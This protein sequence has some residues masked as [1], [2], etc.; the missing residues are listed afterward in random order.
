[1]SIQKTVKNLLEEGKAVDLMTP[2]GFVYLNA[3]QVHAI[4]SG[5]CHEINTNPGCSGS[6][7]HMPVDELLGYILVR[8]GYNAKRDTNE[9]LVDYVH[10]LED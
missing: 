5:E 10:E 1:M 4:I 2:A 3:E 8:G 7:M 6:D 9:Y